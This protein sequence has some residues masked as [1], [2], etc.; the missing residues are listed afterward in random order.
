MCNECGYKH[1]KENKQMSI[2]L[3]GDCLIPVG[4]CACPA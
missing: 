4:D 1:S 3:C 2:V